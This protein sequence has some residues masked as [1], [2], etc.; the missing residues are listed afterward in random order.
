MRRALATKLVAPALAGLALAAC[1]ASADTGTGEATASAT[2]SEIA[3]VDAVGL[4][5]RIARDE[6]RLIDVRTPEEYAEGHIEGATNIPL[7]L[8]DPAAIKEEAG[9]ETV[10]YCRSGRRSAIAADML[11]KAWGKPVRHLSGGVLAWEAARLPL[12]DRKTGCC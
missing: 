5:S 9:K 11:A 12:A 7:N 8:F 6:V 2:R 4:E 3:T 1:S 10:L